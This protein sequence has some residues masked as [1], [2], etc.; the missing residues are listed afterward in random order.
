MSLSTS[1]EAY[2]SLVTVVIMCV[3]GLVFLVKLWRKK[4]ARQ[5][6][7][8]ETL[9]VYEQRIRPVTWTHDAILHPL[10]TPHRHFCTEEPLLAAQ[11][12]AS[13]SMPDLDCNYSVSGPNHLVCKVWY[14]ETFLIHRQDTTFI[15]LPESA[16][17]RSARRDFPAATKL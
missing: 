2:L 3:P 14:A 11:I 13:R 6:R 1:M 4:K 8:P 17:V 7:K 12:L 9:P 15:S 10:P 5:M 16:Y